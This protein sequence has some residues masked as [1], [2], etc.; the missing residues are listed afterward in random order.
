MVQH[1]YV[2]SLFDERPDALKFCINCLAPLG[3]RAF[4]YSTPHAEVTPVLP[5]Q[6][7]HVHTGLH[8][9]RIQEV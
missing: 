9:E 2:S 5:P 7:Y 1:R 8:F 3:Y 6:S 4:V